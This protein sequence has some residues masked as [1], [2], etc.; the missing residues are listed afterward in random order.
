[1]AVVISTTTPNTT[2]T[3]N[4]SGSSYLKNNI[5]NS[6]SLDDEYLKTL[7]QFDKLQKDLDQIKDAFSKLK[8][9]EH[10]ADGPSGPIKKLKCC[11][12][13]ISR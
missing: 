1:M 6:H 2:T 3:D 5:N 9:Y 12:D 13:D 10:D 8:N 7:G 11:L 4:N